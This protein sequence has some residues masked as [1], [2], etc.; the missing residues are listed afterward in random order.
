MHPIAF[1]AVCLVICSFLRSTS[2]G[3]KIK[4]ENYDCS[5]WV[6]DNDAPKM[7]IPFTSNGKR[8]SIIYP[9]AKGRLNVKGG[10]SF[11]LSCGTA[12]FASDAIRKNHTADALVTCV[13]DDVLAYRGHTYPY[14][15]F[16]C[17]GMP[18]SEL[19]VT[20]ELCQSGKYTVATVGFQTERAFLRLYSMCFDKSTKNSLYSWYDPRFPFYDNHQK[21]SKR[22]SFTKSKELYGTTDVNK[23]YTLKEQKKTV[24]QILRSEELADKYIRND[25]KH[26]LSRGHYTAKAD[27]FFAYEQIATFYYANVAPQW[28]IFNG[29]MW[30]ELEQSTRTKLDK[31]NSSSRHVIVTGT[32]GVCTLADVDNVQQPLY[33]DLPNSI[34]VPLL[35]WKLHYNVDSADGIVYIGLNNPY[36]KIDDSVFI[37][38]NTCPDGHHNRGYLDNGR[39]NSEPEPDANDGLIYCCTKESFEK[40]YGELDPIVYRPLM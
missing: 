34:P 36:K 19:R 15:E 37:C 4:A 8:Y 33:L 23:K 13:G 7:P 10:H 21:Y 24:A 16:Q 6:N 27:F 22:P 31:D 29:D 18:K 38:P 17:D 11:K 32:Y 3:Y 5:L 35:Y 39:P 12:K 25:N 30:A 9:D 28:Q 20:D 2:Y 1:S 14:A 40:A 26:S